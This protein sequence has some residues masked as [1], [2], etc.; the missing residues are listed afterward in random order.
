MEL[1]K[2]LL[3]EGLGIKKKY[4]GQCDLLRHKSPENEVKWHLMMDGKK[5]I[6]FKT[7]I[8][9]VEFESILDEDENPTDFIKDALRADPSTSAYISNWGDEPCMF[10]QTA[11]FEFIFV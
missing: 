2:K 5:Q 9:S 11:G 4:L 10:L 7:L 1:I 8:D 6:P 3:R